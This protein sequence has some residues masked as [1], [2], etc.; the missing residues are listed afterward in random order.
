MGGCRRRQPRHEGA[1]NE[2]GQRDSLLR[3]RHWFLELFRQAALV[4]SQFSW[5]WSELLPTKLLGQEGSS[6]LEEGRVG[7]RKEK[8]GDAENV[9]TAC[10]IS[11]LLINE[12]TNA[13]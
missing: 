4:L 7:Q 9:F 12:V 10:L 6:L 1:L 13:R 3:E 8:L 2:A 5:L 11:L